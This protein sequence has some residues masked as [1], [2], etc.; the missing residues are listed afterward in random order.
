MADLAAGIGLFR[1]LCPLHL[2]RASPANRLTFKKSLPVYPGWEVFMKRSDF[3]M[4]ILTAVLFLAVASYI[5]VYVVNALRNTFV[6]MTA[7]SYT[8]EETLPAEGFIV[9]T[10]TVMSDIS[11]DI[12]PFVS[13]GERVGVG[14]VV[15]R[16]YFT[17]QALETAS[18]IRAIRLKL[19]NF[20]NIRVGADVG[21]QSVMA[22]SRAV[23]SGNL[24]ALDEIALQIESTIF[25][26]YALSEDEVYSLR[27]RLH[28]LESQRDGMTSVTAP[29]SGIFSG[30][31]DGFEFISPQ[32]IRN[33]TPSEL[34]RLFYAPAGGFGGFK[35]ITEFKWYFV[36]IMDAAD[37]NRLSVGRT[38]SLQFAGA[39]Q[40]PVD[41]LVENI[42]RREG[43]RVVVLF[44]SN[45]GIHEITAQRFLQADIIFDNIMGIRVPKEALHLDDNGVTH[46]FLQT[47]ARA[48]RVNV[49]I[50]T[51]IGDSFIVRDGAETG[52]PL[53]SGSTII[54]RAN[55]LF[56]GRVVG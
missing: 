14:Q 17:R 16:E 56:H 52:S 46:V 2:T 53:R 45:R 49:E 4:K 47:G 6:T 10:E 30:F 21:F 28:F 39:F 38:V 1:E 44:S 13:E 40:R 36:A 27:E 51:I 31:A 55:N 42:G 9:R 29:V 8:I 33:L 15:G 5:G 41:M 20:D 50:L 3:Y 43:E 25:A 54:V 24:S 32:D 22:L 11:G 34:L 19:E 23:Q 18:E 37:A 48:E 26:Q 12:L 35:M 7:G